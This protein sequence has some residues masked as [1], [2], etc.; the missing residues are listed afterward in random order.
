MEEMEKARE[1]VKGGCHKLKEDESKAEWLRLHPGYMVRGQHPKT[2][3][4]SLRGMC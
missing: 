1:R 2:K 3:E 4:W